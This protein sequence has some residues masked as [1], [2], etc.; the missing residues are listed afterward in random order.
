MVDPVFSKEDGLCDSETKGLPTA[1]VDRE[2][3]NRLLSS[4]GND[5]PCWPRLEMTNELGSFLKQ[6]D[7]VNTRVLAR[8]EAQ[9][10]RLLSTDLTPF[11]WIVFGTHGYVGHDLPGLPD[12]ALVFT[13]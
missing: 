9:K 3:D 12:S 1:L 11:R 10:S 6:L 2:S 7:P 13:R 4:S 5:T 8:F